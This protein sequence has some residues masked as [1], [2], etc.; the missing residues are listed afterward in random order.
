MYESK[1][2]EQKLATSSLY[3][4]NFRIAV[5]RG[6]FEM[7]CKRVSSWCPTWRYPVKFL[8]GVEAAVSRP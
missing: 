7:S 2:D 5:S 6:D 3:P 1:L 4:T 8:M